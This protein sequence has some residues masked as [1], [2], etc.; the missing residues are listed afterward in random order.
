VSRP[1]AGLPRAA[2]ASIADSERRHRPR[3]GHQAA[4]YRANLKR[5]RTDARSALRE[6]IDGIE[7]DGWGPFDRATSLRVDQLVVV[8]EGERA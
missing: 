2:E 3:K 8:I 4:R 7:R 1:D 5:E 6:L